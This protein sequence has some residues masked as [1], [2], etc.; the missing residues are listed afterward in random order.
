MTSHEDRVR[1]S[2]IKGSEKLEKSL[3][4][5]SKVRFIVY[6]HASMFCRLYKLHVI[7]E[8]STVAYQVVHVEHNLVDSG[9]CPI[10]V[11]M[12]WGQ[13]QTGIDRVAIRCFG[14]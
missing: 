12:I 7:N 10:R 13:R 5:K 3:L 14:F 4:K 1:L 8:R 2:Q 6:I 11:L 9:L